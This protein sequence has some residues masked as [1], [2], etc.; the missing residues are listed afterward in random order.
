MS[1][2]RSPAAITPEDLKQAVWEARMTMEQVVS[3][4]EDQLDGL[5]DKIGKRGSRTLE[6]SSDTLNLLVLPLNRMLSGKAT[7]VADQM[8]SLRNEVESLNRSKR[9][10]VFQRMLRKTPVKQYVH[11]YRAASSNVESIVRSLREGRETLEENMLFMRKI[12]RS[13]LENV[14]DLKF[15][16]EYG[17]RLKQL[18]EQE[19]EKP[20]Y[21]HRRPYLERGL[22]KVSAKIR[23]FEE[24]VMLYQQAIAM[25]DV[26]CDTNDKLIDAVEGTIDK[27]RHLMAVSVLV[28][29]AIDDQ[30][31]VLA[32]VNA[33]H[34][35]I[36]RQ[37]AENA[38][39]LKETGAMAEEALVRPAGGMELV[40][41]VMADLNAALDRYE[42]S[43]REIVRS[44][45]EQ[46][47]RM[48]R[49]NRETGRRLGL[50]VA[51]SAERAVLRH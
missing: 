7:E 13:S 38:R 14:Y 43:N 28:A 10:T 40:D 3:V 42:R 31:Q 8:L 16:I 24:M 15:L 23:T 49:L 6:R 50:E 36:D 25:T 12:K 33:A 44:L 46:T 9:L 11:K 29:K 4:D 51:E 17:T 35:M 48:S 41:R 45:S 21:A 39:L 18:F 20:V 47:D 5:M 30:F 22:R 37:F 27:T 34:D 26:V 19:L 1:M 2:E 32:A